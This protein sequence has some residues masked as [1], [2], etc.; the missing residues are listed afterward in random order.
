MK[1]NPGSRTVASPQQ[2]QFLVMW[3]AAHGLTGVDN[4]RTGLHGLETVGIEHQR[5]WLEYHR[6]SYTN[7]G[8]SSNPTG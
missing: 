2:L 1:A 3:G 5:P 4:D 6:D 8:I 7:I